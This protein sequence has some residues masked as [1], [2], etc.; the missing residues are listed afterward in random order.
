[1]KVN[2][3]GGWVELREPAEVPERLRRP[4]IQLTM[5][6]VPLQPHFEAL[7]NDP[8]SVDPEM[9]AKFMEY[10]ADFGDVSV[11]AL[12]KEWSFGPV[13]KDSLL[14]LPS[15]AYD[16]IQKA[17]APHITA[18]LPNFGVDPDPKATT[19]DSIA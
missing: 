19:D 11:L 17:V 1:M 16:E 2:V 10:N 18:L 5:A 7:Q 15:A 3:T 9:F 4:L 8:S 6:G 14:D 12:V 13:T